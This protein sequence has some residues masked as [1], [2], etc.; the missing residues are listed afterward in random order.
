M[1]ATE[2][3]SIDSQH[4]QAHA[5]RLAV[6]LAGGFNLLMRDGR[7][8][9]FRGLT[10]PHELHQA[11]ADS[12]A[13]FQHSQAQT[14]RVDAC[15][16]EALLLDCAREVIRNRLELALRRCLPYRW[17]ASEEWRH[18]FNGAQGPDLESAEA[19]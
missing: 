9:Q 12:F 4:F 15:A 10:R 13:V 3:E 18:T 16:V 19:T 5:W 2:S 7:R 6:Y 14:P 8:V 11:V 17:P 1:R